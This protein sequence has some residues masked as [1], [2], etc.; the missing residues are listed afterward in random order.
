[1]TSKQTRWIVTISISATSR[2]KA[3]VAAHLAASRP[4]FGWGD[5]VFLKASVRP[6]R[7]GGR[8]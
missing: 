5:A 7:H 8:S 6:R 4:D 1:M 2:R 3:I